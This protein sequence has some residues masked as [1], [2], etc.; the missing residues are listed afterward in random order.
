MGILSKLAA[1]AP[2]RGGARAG[3]A[4]A[5]SGR[6][7]ASL[8]HETEFINRTLRYQLRALRARSR[9]ATQNNPFGR[10]FVQLA[11]DNVAGPVPF[12]LQGKVR[13]NNGRF[14]DA[15]NRQIEAV[16]R[17]WGR[18]GNCEVTER[19]HWNTLQRLLV[20]TLV[21][22]GEVLFRKLRG[23]DFGPHGFKLQLIDADLL[24]DQLNKSLP[25]GGAIHMGVELDPAGKPVA[26]HLLKR[27]PRHW[28]YGYTPRE[29]ERVPAEDI[30]H[31][32]VPLLIDQ[33]R[34]VPWIYAALLNLVHLGAGEEAAV[35]AFRVGAAQMGF[36]QQADDATAPLTGDSTDAQG[37][38]QIE[39]EPGAFPRLPPGYEI[40]GW[41]PRYPDAAVEP[42]VKTM[43]RGI[44]SALGVAYHNLA[45]D[46]SD[47]NYST[48][49]VFGSEEHAM[50]MGV[51]QF[52]ID[53]AHEPLYRD[54]LRMQIVMR[55]LPFQLERIEKY[56]EVVWHARRWPSP[57]P[58]KDAKADVELIDNK[59]RSRTRA[60]AERGDDVEDVFDE[61]KHEQDLADQK[62]LKLDKPT[63]A[64]PAAPEG[65]TPD[66]TTTEGAGAAGTDSD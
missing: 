54:W 9:Q 36:I 25:G 10:R 40:S 21:V 28:Q 38:P 50:W 47:V 56:T 14:D 17:E 64:A 29:R 7:T 59:L 53:H 27:K 45:N 37:N 26:Y 19:W 44:A 35:I 57:D 31:V 62:G 66:E 52:L 5:D 32:F 46:P 30:E 16:W 51:Q 6:L 22:D 33:N 61:L 24:D 58:L 3:F 13:F 55:K 15:A 34:G 60:I 63:P 11:A 43:L 12:R 48:A 49:K 2:R 39:A 65:E 41:N 1:P 18:K 23:P 42:F 8:A 20:Q 4:A